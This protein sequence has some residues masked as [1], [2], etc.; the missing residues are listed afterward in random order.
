MTEATTHCKRRIL[1]IITR[2]NYTKTCDHTLH[3]ILD[4]GAVC[5][6]QERTQ[7]L[8]LPHSLSIFSPQT[9]NIPNVGTKVI[10]SI[11]F[12]L[13]WC[14]AEF[15]SRSTKI[16]GVAV[17]YVHSTQQQCEMADTVHVHTRQRTETEFHSVGGSNPKKI[18][19]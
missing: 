11:L 6:K 4:I 19:R 8:S 10:T 18:R 1:K 9:G 3:I 16:T 17:S 2:A 15:L 12:H 14:C 7:S 5:Y 13:M